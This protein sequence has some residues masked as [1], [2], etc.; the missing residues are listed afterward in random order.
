MI[1]QAVARREA[2]YYPANPD[3]PIPPLWWFCV[4]R[5]WRWGLIV[6]GELMAIALLWLLDA[7]AVVW[8]ILGN[9]I[10]FLNGFQIRGTYERNR[11]WKREHALRM[12]QL[13]ARLR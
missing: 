12:A 4:V 10:W 1:R 11:V 7:P 8:I 3:G 5:G 13:E 2:G 6:V 9:V